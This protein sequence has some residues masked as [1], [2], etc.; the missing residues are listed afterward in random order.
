MLVSTDNGYETDFFGDSINIGTVLVISG[1]KRFYERISAVEDSCNESIR[2]S[3][4]LW[5]ERVTDSLVFRVGAE[6][7]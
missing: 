6:R 2:A 7:T 3:T 1:L 5:I 4:I